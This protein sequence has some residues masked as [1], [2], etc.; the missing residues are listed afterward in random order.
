[1]AASYCCEMMSGQLGRTCAD[2]PDAADCPDMLVA[3]RPSGD[4]VLLVHDGGSS[5]IAIAFC[6][7]CGRDLKSVA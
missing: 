1:M 6:P 3:R 5:G 2:H 4:H 7:W